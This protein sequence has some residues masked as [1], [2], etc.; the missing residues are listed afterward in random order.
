MLK[1]DNEF[2]E[3]YLYHTNPANYSP[4]LTQEQFYE[5]NAMNAQHEAEQ[6][7]E[8]AW[9]RAAELPTNDDLAFEQWERERGCY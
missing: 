6:Y 9:L 1:F 2:N 3:I 7:A 8:N 5:Q 4:L